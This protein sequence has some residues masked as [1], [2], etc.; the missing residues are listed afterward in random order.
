[1]V[2]VL[3][4]PWTLWPTGSFSVLENQF[5]E[6]LIPLGFPRSSQGPGDWE[7]DAQPELGPDPCHWQEGSGHV[8][9]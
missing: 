2:G 4:W 9:L 5:L 7:K 6:K 8:G 1:M 3:G